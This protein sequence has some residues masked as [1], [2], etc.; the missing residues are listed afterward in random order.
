MNESWIRVAEGIERGVG[1][2]DVYKVKRFVG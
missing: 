1:L 2:R